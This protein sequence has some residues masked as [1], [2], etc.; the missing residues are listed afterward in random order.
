MADAQCVIRILPLPVLKELL[1]D[2]QAGEWQKRKKN[3]ENEMSKVKL[4][5][6]WGPA[7][8]K[9]YCA[10]FYLLKGESLQRNYSAEN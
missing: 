1:H 6:F 3:T 2:M 5:R 9:I 10:Y 7:I 4:E 8:C